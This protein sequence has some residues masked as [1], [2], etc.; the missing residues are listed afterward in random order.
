MIGIFQAKKMQLQ[1]LQPSPGHARQQRPSPSWS[2]NPNPNPN[3]SQGSFK[4]DL[5]R[6]GRLAQWV[7][8]IAAKPD[9]LG[10]IP[11]TPWVEEENWLLQVRQHVRK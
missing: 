9:G 5:L 1:V 4:N 8:T 6:V 11:G 3:S 2:C 7:K 10:S